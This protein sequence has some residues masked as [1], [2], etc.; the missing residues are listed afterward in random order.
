[1]KPVLVNPYYVKKTKELDNNS[2]TKNDR[3]D[4]KFIAGLVKEGRIWH[5]E[6]TIRCTICRFLLL[7]VSWCRSS[8]YH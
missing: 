8:N 5:H 3:K 4:P 1:M 2:Q 6:H 7:G